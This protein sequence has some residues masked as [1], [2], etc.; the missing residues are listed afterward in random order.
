MRTLDTLLGIPAVMILKGI[1]RLV[2]PIKRRKFDRDKVKNILV[3]KCFGMGSILLARPLLAGIRREFPQAKLHLLTFESNKTLVGMVPEIDQGWYI[4]TRSGKK[5]GTS[6]LK[7]FYGLRKTGIDLSFDLEFF[8]KFTTMCSLISGS[9]WRTGFFLQTK[10]RE[11]AYTH[12]A[13]FNS[14][15]HVS[16][17]FL[18]QLGYALAHPNQVHLELDEMSPDALMADLPPLKF[19]NDNTASEKSSEKIIAIN[20]NASDLSTLRRWPRK[21]YIQVIRELL[22]RDDSTR[23]YLIGG[24]GENE[25]VDPVYK[26]FADSDRVVNACG[27]MNI[28]ELMSF[29]SE[30][31]LLIGND[32]GPL[33]MAACQGTDTISI[34]GP[35]TPVLYG[36]AGSGWNR[37]LYRGIFCSP[38]LN[39]YNNKLSTC[40]NNLCVKEIGV[41]DVMKAYDD[42]VAFCA[43]RSSSQSPRARGHRQT[44][45]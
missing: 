28:P 19:D 35:E 24:P 18:G 32:S 8:S 3:I 10:W 34:F 21:N 43:D 41:S 40:Q 22:E 1:D 2:S 20:V 42:W 36:P 29:L 4:S 9:P 25:Y 38:C 5:F 17:V 44:T 27:K 14:H 11:G 37:A 16:L 23:I 15:Q 39:V 6:V 12:N 33:H 45:R 13:Y 26:K 31:S 30:I 7:A